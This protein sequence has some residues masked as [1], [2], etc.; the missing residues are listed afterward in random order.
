MYVR[1]VRRLAVGLVVTLALFAAP[2]AMSPATAA[3]L[4]ATPADPPLPSYP[5]LPPLTGSTTLATVTTTPTPCGD[6]GTDRHLTRNE[7]LTR[8]RSWL[9]VGIPYSQERCYRNSYGDYRTDCSGFVSMA[10]G[11]GGS[12][13]SYWTGNLD[14]QSYPI[15]RSSLQ[16]GDALLRHTGD[17]AEN[18]VA[19]FV[20]WADSAHTQPVVIEQTGSRDTVQDSWSSSYASLYTPARYT[21]IV[22]T[23]MVDVSL[24]SGRSYFGDGQHHVYERGVGDSLQHFWYTVGDS[25]WD[26]AI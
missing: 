21:N 3:V 1:L 8:A 22:E 7:V 5:G 13:S 26:K 10:W 24:S 23:G 15:T 18:H 11:L 16:P 6:N 4:T 9:S 12:G 14:L 20:E 17:P 25:G 19:L 2:Q